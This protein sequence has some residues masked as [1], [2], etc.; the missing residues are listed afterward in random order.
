MEINAIEVRILLDFVFF[1]KVYKFIDT[2]T[3]KN[4]DCVRN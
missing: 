3:V 1:N 4:L 2:L